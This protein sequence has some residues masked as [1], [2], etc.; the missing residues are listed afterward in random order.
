LSV[1]V[2]DKKDFPKILEQVEQGSIAPI[3]LLHGEDYLVKSALE[4]LT[5][6]LVPESQRSTN[7]QVVDGGEADFRQILDSVNTFALFGGRKVIVVRNSRIFYS[8]ANLPALVAKSKEGYEAGDLKTAAR[9][10][11]EVLGYAEWSLADVAAGAWREIPADLWKQTMGVEQGQSELEWLE[12]VV[13]YASRAEMEIPI[14]TDEGSLLEE[15]LQQGFPSEHCLLITTDTIDRRRSLYRLMEEKGIVADFSVTSGTG[16]KA[17]SQQEAVLRNLAK[18]ILSAAGK[19]IEPEALSL[20]LERTGFNLWALKT[21]LEKIISFVGE[22]SL[23]TLEQAESMSDQFREEALYE[24]NNSV[25]ERNCEAALQV[26][27]RL[28][29]QNYHPLQVLASLATEVR[30]LLLAREFI[31]E[32]LAGSL[33]PSI[34]YGSFQKTVLPIVKEKTEKGSPLGSMHPFALHKTLV[35]SRAYQ[36]ADLINALQHLFQT[37]LTLKSS[38]IAGRAVMESLIMRL[39]RL[40]PRPMPQSSRQ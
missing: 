16:R 9:L 40:T 27:N 28:L 15:A 32:H 21:Q 31:E 37:D 23:V 12:Q 17:R 34:S 4:E 22:E 29:D 3:Y 33:D 5:E 24:L 14:K 19:K 10:L 26:L 6:L 25:T 30:R 1:P 36:T 18:R 35:R 20:L 13:E 11:L 7:L 2:F 38:G 8:R 39:C